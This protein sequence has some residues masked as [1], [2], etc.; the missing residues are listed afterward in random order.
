ML[1]RKI[2][3]AFRKQDWATVAVEFVIVVAGIFVGL[4]ADSWNTARND[5]IREQAILEQLH[6][7]FVSNAAAVIQYADR[8]EQMAAELGFA[9]DVLTRGQISD[10][11]VVRFR[12]AFVSMYQLPSI[13]ASMGGYDAVI[14]SGDLALI[15]DQEL[16]NRLVNLSSELDSEI[17][18]M[19][20][21]RDMN[22]INAELTRDVVLLVPNSDRSDVNLRV[23]F[24]VVKEDYRMLTV[25]AGQ[26]RTHRIFSDAR[27]HL[28]ENFA[29]TAA[30]IESIQ[31]QPDR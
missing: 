29:D 13:S 3:T 31:A 12:N 25:V 28:A 27:R 15:S 5:R 6:A 16:K 2:A 17:S 18:L 24:D 19:N 21:F 7:D 30:Y 9:L 14:A 4:Q 22:N 20:Y 8:H 10:E 1:L 26:Q 23:D 11:E